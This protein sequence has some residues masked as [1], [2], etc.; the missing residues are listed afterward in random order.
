MRTEA[1]VPLS[2]VIVADQSGDDVVAVAAWLRKPR[3]CLVAFGL[4]RQVAERDKARMFISCL[5]DGS[6][7]VTYE[8]L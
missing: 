8:Q 4:P 6:A 5:S 3:H 7:A 2:G 1:I